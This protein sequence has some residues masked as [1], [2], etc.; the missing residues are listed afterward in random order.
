MLRAA[1]ASDIKNNRTPEQ[2]T[3]RFCMPGVN[4]PVPNNYLISRGSLQ[5]TFFAVVNGTARQPLLANANMTVAQYAKANG[6]EANDLYTIILYSY[7][8]T[9]Y[10]VE[11]DDGD[12][13]KGIRHLFFH[14]IQLQVKEGLEAVNE[15]VTSLEQLFNVYKHTTTYPPDLSYYQMTNRTRTVI[16]TEDVIGHDGGAI[17]VIR[18]KPNEKLRSTSYMQI[19]NVTQQGCGVVAPY[20]LN[21]WGRNSNTVVTIE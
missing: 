21:F 8:E 17:G 1:L 6:L 19:N 2:C 5:Q 11:P 12:S 13:F 16:S 15:V 10:Y 9:V 14:Y 4:M 3:A 18:S 7:N 20:L